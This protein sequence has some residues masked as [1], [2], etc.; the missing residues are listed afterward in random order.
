MRNISD[1]EKWN[2]YIVEERA[3]LE[4]LKNIAHKVKIDYTPYIDSERMTIVNIINNLV[5]RMCNID[6]GYDI[7][8]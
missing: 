1:S 8:D 3:Y 2:A 5:D 4:L 7:D 6:G